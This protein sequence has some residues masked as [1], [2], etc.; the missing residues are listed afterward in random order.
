MARNGEGTVHGEV[1]FIASKLENDSKPAL[2][3]TFGALIQHL[4]IMVYRFMIYF[5]LRSRIV[6]VPVRHKSNIL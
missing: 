3:N 4:M 5:A 6:H 1:D 2:E